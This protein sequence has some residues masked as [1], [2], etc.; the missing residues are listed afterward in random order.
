MPR[1][2]IFVLS[3]SYLEFIKLHKNILEQK[4]SS[5]GASVLLTDMTCYPDILSA[6]LTDSSIHKQTLFVTDEP[7][8]FHKLLH[9]GL[10]VIALYHD[11][12]QNCSFPEAS[13]AVEDIL[14][15]E[16]RSYTEAYKR[17]AHLPWDILETDRLYV[18]ESTPD[19]IPDFYRLYQAP[20]ISDFMEPLFE[21]PEEER[22][23]LQDYIKQVY[24]FYGFGIWTVILKSTGQIIGRAGLNI[25]EGYELPELGFIIDSALQNRGLAFEVCSAILTYAKEELYFDQIQAFVREENIP[26]RKLLEKLGFTYHRTVIENNREYLQMLFA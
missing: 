12:N 15:L 23:Y 6:Q 21:N 14:Q 8:I 5:Y 26:S 4:V 19:D 25:R 10:Y 2:I 20:G 17:L 16:Y 11:N 22:A 3:G 9:A 1:K 7:E 13:Y 18:R 24:G